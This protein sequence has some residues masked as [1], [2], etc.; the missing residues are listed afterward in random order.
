MKTINNIALEQKSTVDVKTEFPALFT[1]IG[2]FKKELEIQIKERILPFSQ[3]VPRNVAI[4]LLSKLK[5]ELDRL[6][7][8][9]IIVPVDYP[10]DWCSP[11][12]VVPKKNSD[13]IRLCCD[14]FKLNN[15]VKK[16]NYLI[17]KVD[18]ALASLKK[19]KIFSKL[20]AQAGFHQIKLAKDSRPL[21][22][23]ITPFGR[24]MF[25]RLPFGINCA[26]EYFSQRFKELLSGLPNV[27]VHIDDVLIH[28]QTVEEHDRILRLVLN[29][30]KEEGIT[31]NKEK[32]KIGVNTIEFL[33]HIISEKGIDILPKRVTAIVKFPVPTNKESLL[34]FLGMVNYASKLYPTSHKY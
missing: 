26:P 14:Y 13:S 20:D 34:Q 2:Q 32:C 8:L 9:K 21:T 12:V 25:T 19:S 30:F 23:F 5:K 27:I 6:I 3:S 10:T 4:P 17:L 11:I 18:I 16:A 31:L 22:T 29:R 24:F 1:E 28:A 15:S 7:K 33:G